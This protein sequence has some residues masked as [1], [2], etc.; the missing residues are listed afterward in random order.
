MTWML[1]FITENLPK[2][3]HSA[4]KCG[5]DL[6]LGPPEANTQRSSG[7]C[8]QQWLFRA[9]SLPFTR[10]LCLTARLK[11]PLLQEIKTSEMLWFFFPACQFSGAE[12][13]KTQQNVCLNL[14]LTRRTQANE[15]DLRNQ[16]KTCLVISTVRNELKVSVFVVF[17]TLCRSIKA[18][19]HAAKKRWAILSV[20]ELI[21]RDKDRE[22]SPSLFVQIRPVSLTLKAIWSKNKIWVCTGRPSLGVP[23]WAS[24]TGCPS[25]GIPH[26]VL[27]TG[28]PSLGI[29]HWAS[30]TGCLSLSVH[31]WAP[32]TGCPSLGVPHL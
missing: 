17:L 31:Y 29:P 19:K 9:S 14:R 8:S 2:Q 4:S 13:T 30:I 7:V 10:F 22:M 16:E 26:W 21:W 20:S 28:C 6:V 5:C 1:L 12:K 32:L 23:H 24:I 3:N 18:S 11:H 27:L 15:I 25:L